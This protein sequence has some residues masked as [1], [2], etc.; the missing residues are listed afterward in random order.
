MTFEQM[1]L[2]R[3]YFY[4]HGWE[5]INHKPDENGFVLWEA[6]WIKR[7][8]KGDKYYSNIFVTNIIYPKRFIISGETKIGSFNLEIYTEEEL[9]NV[10]KVV[11]IYDYYQKESKLKLK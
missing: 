10:L 1:L 3:E 4:L 6:R 2:T 11:G 7:F 9:L 5:I 8:E